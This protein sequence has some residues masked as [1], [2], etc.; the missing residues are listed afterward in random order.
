MQ[1][2]SVREGREHRWMI[3]SVEESIA[4][5]EV[6]GREMVQLPS[7]II[8]ADAREG[9][10]LRV[11]HERSGDR[12][13]LRVEIDRDATRAANTRSRQQV[14]QRGAKPDPGGDIRL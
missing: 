11:T 9:D 6:D 2:D 14:T 10:V 3:D 7:W 5:I 13:A 4:S 12:S 8:P 1:S